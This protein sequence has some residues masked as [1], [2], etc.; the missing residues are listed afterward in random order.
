MLK[1]TINKI[2]MKNRVLRQREF[3]LSEV[4][5]VTY[6]DQTLLSLNKTALFFSVHLWRRKKVRKKSSLCGLNFVMITYMW[7]TFI[8]SWNKFIHYVLHGTIRSVKMNTQYIQHIHH[9]LTL[10]PPTHSYPHR[11][12]TRHSPDIEQRLCLMYN[13]ITCGTIIVT[14]KMFHYTW[15][16]DCKQKNT[17]IYTCNLITALYKNNT[18]IKEFN[19]SNLLWNWITKNCQSGQY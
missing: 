14:L 9:I 16:A 8:K 15:F 12:H 13:N 6:W 11:S 18:S 17:V 5:T 2:I 4:K 10:P 3:W 1:N 19:K 7:L